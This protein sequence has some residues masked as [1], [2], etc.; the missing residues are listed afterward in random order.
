MRTR[1]PIDMTMLAGQL[2]W[3]TRLRWV[4]G[5]VV[6]GGGLVDWLWLGW[7]AGSW[8]IVAIG[9][10]ILA[11]NVVLWLA[12]PRA[13]RGGTAARV[14]ASVHIV[15]DLAC[16]SALSL[17]TG[18][19]ESPVLGFFVLHMVFASLLL[20]RVLAYGAAA[21]AVVLLSSG[22]A[23]TG[24]WPADRAGWV[25]L[26]AWCVV[27][28]TIVYLASHITG[29]LRRHRRRLLAKQRRIRDLMAQMQ[30]QQWAL[31]HH[32]KMAAM[33]QMAAGLAH[34]IGNPLAS[35]DSLLQLAERNDRPLTPEKQASLREG[36]ARIHETIQY[37][38][39]FAHP[40]ELYWQT[41]T[42]QEMIDQALRM[43]H[44]DR[45]SRRITVD[46]QLDDP[47]RRVH[48][49]PHAMQQVLTNVLLNAVDAL[50][51]TE[52]PR[53][54]I[55]TQTQD[56]HCV[57]TL[58]DN[59][60]GIPPEHLGQVCKPFFTTKPVGKGTGLGLAV[61][62]NLIRN[63]D[64][65]LTVLSEPGRGTTVRISLPLRVSNARSSSAAAT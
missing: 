13:R 46:W 32:E 16:L 9:L 38:T 34:E 53:L 12:L 2:A 19:T 43:L 65:Q 15:L 58:T 11:Y 3:L 27:L 22:L 4:A 56:G 61:S 44:F 14:S 33:G 57:I 30:R 18:A 36:I 60:P 49:Q 42:P 25:E 37:M 47:Q 64:G 23:V 6:L 28:V 41:V 20:P 55:R 7:H 24:L 59:G 10:A 35:M 1:E 39:A 63:Q 29:R 45:R 52:D 17:C 26:V 51:E 54:T 62:E 40:T 48:V 50:E 31:V 21:A 5:A 8:R